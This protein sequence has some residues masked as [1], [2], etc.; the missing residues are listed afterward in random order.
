MT[1][2]DDRG[3]MSG[4]S[5]TVRDGRIFART[6]PSL[7]VR[8]LPRKSSPC[9]PSVVGQRSSAG[10]PRSYKNSCL[11]FFAD[12]I[13]IPALQISTALQISKTAHFFLLKREPRRAGQRR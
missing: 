1:V 2:T 7:T 8:L 5:P 3:L 12:A 9:K 6:A 11:Y 13:R 10:F 4:S